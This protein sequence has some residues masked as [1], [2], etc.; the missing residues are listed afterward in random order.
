MQVTPLVAPPGWNTDGSFR[1]LVDQAVPVV[2]EA[3]DEN[4]RVVH[5]T[6]IKDVSLVMPDG[7]WTLVYSVDGHKWGEYRA[8]VDAT[9]PSITGLVLHGDANSGGSY[10]ISGTPEAGSVVSVT[11]IFTGEKVASALPVTVGPLQDGIHAFLVEATDAA[12]NVFR[13]TVQ[14]RAG[15]AAELPQ[16]T[17]T[18]GVVARYTNS[19]RLWD[20]TDLKAYHTP[21]EARAAVPAAYLNEGFGI[22]PQD[23]TVIEIVDAVVKPGM[24]T[25]EIA[26]ELFRWLADNLEYDELRLTTDTLLTPHQV[27]ND[28]EDPTDNDEDR[29]GLV[30]NGPGNGVK[31]GICR[32]LAATYVSLLRAAGVPARLVSGYLAGNVDGF[33]AWVEFYGGAVSGQ[34][35]WIP[36]DVSPIDGPYE[37]KTLLQAFGIQLPDY[38]P[39]RTVPPAGEITGWATALSVRYEWPQQE[40]APKV[41][42]AKA[43]SVAFDENGVMC[44]NSTTR[45]R[46][47]VENKE[48][49]PTGTYNLF[50]PT[51]L[52]RTQRTIDYGIKLVSAPEGSTI[53]AEVAFPYPDA[54]G[55]NEVVYEFYGPAFELDQNGGKAK[56]EIR[57]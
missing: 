24:T 40:A 25:A 23:P 27:L 52:Q 34:S 16:G 39:L 44:I 35:P 19:V 32:D 47:M 14:V 3:T 7:I 4:G 15:V 45:A 29:D 13:G 56:T 1:V 42:F 22:E 57:T 9:A 30:R 21:S 33:H 37:V 46:L 28:R 53:W 55:T 6:G 18:F 51:V 50:L 5:A 48:N 12:G 26:V 36:V 2:I 20:L 10:T 17:N 49:C 41:D 54:S 43:V 11:N 38:L 31:G 8:Q